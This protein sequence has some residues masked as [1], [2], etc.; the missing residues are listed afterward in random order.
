MSLAPGTRIGPYEIV[1]PLGGGGMGEVFRAKDSKLGREVAIKVLP[2]A[3]AEDAERLRRFEQE[4]RTLAALSHPNIVQVFEA[5][6]HEGRPYLVMELLE[7]ETLRDGLAKGRLPWRK[8]VEL[9][10]AVADGLAAAHAKGIVHRDLKPENLVFSEHGHL[11]ILDF[12]LAKLRPTTLGTAATVDTAPP[13][14]MDGSL[15]GTVGYMAP[16]QVRGLAVDARADVFALG[17]VLFELVKGSRAFAR[18]ST[19]DTLAAILNDPVPEPSLSGSGGTPELDR[20]LS[21]CLEKAP[22]DRFQSA[23]DLAFDL[24]TLLTSAP[25]S[26]SAAPLEASR[27]RRRW[28][29][30]AAVL[31]GLAAVVAGLL[32][33]S[34]WKATVPAYDPRTIA[35]LPFENRTGDPSLDG[36]GQQVVDLL[37]QDLQ[38]L[39]RITVAADAP[40]PPGGDST[41]SLAQAT[42]AR[43]V[44]AGAYYLKGEQ[45]EFQARVVDPWAGKV[46]YTLGPWRGPKADPAPALMELRQRVAGAAAWCFEDGLR[47]EPGATRPPR[48]DAM[49]TIRK[50]WKSFGR[51]YAVLTAAAQKA[52][53]QDPDFAVGRWLLFFALENQDKHEEAAKVLAEMEADYG[54]STPVERCTVRWC[55]AAL[56]GRPLEVLKAFEDLKAIHP[57]TYMLRYNRALYERAVNRTGSAIRSLTGIPPNWV[58]EGMHNDFWPANVLGWVHH[59]AGDPAAQLRVAREAQTAFPDVMAF[60]V[61]EAAA[62]G[63]LG[64]LPELDRMLESAQAIAPRPATGTAYGALFCALVELRGHGH[65]EA[66]Q[67]MAERLL[68]EVRGRSPEAQKKVRW[69]TAFALLALDRGAEALEVYRA[70]VAEDPNP[71]FQGGVG[72]TL[73]R[74]GRADEARKVEA[75]LAALGRPYLYGIHTYARAEIAAQLGEKDRAVALLRQA[76]GQGYSYDV[77]L[78][79]DLFVEPLHGY[80][81]YEDLMK[82]KD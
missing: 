66:S 41:R 54:R 15:L 67:R 81:P 75:E 18:I 64:R 68:V 72:A 11:K 32:L 47:F 74:L 9:A 38:P 55:R 77:D 57:D 20:I 50:D 69:S 79:Q 78:H 59:Q 29:L 30:P 71:L 62:L 37:R 5:G 19:V 35:I 65:R 44:A 24:R 63:A 26:A 56:E 17:C 61:Q 58:S 23:K 39:D 4:A 73:A 46:I 14:T 82:P 12:G 52:I 13:G 2:E 16:E 36:L 53:E 7:G 42:R 1:A 27:G 22:G 21:H 25:A 33:W 48:L 43:Y 28:M 10:A 34:P 80:P 31:L 76:F 49:L 40:I 6:E 51:D 8:A 45:V 60:R 70:L 3:F